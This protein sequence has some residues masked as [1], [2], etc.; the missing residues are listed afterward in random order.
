MQVTILSKLVV[1]LLSLSLAN[2]V[3]IE[4]WSRTGCGGNSRQ[5]S[6]IAANRCCA[7][8]TRTYSSSRFIGIIESELGAVC[9]RSGNRNCGT[10]K[11]SNNGRRVC[12]SR[13]TLLGLRGSYWFSC[14]SCMKRDARAIGSQFVDKPST[15]A[16]TV[17]PDKVIIDG[18]KFEINHPNQ[19]QETTDALDALVDSEST[20]YDNMDAALR[21]WEVPMGPD[22]E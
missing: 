2:A 12:V 19:S 3:T 13:P 8:A 21:Q 4:N 1:L 17:L 15:A 11:A 6:N 10:I 9:S 22:D 5:C 7:S 16:D 18:H 14:L 20:V